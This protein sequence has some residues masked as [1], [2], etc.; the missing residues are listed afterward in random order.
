MEEQELN[1]KLAE[2]VGFKKANI[3][4][5]YHYEVGIRVPDW[6]YPSDPR[7]CERE[8]PNFPESLDACFKWLVPKLDF[9]QMELYSLEDGTWLFHLNYVG[10]E[11]KGYSGRGKTPA[12]AL[13]LAIEELIGQ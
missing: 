6:L 11:D 3:K 2:W 4:W 1:T 5:D 12:L 8:L 13:C 9:G 10:K 7:Y